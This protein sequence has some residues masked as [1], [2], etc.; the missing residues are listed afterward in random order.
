MEP[1]MKT[2]GVAKSIRHHEDIAAATIT[3]DEGIYEEFKN[4]K[5]RRRYRYI[6]MKIVEAKVVIESTAPPTASFESFIAALP[7]ADS[8]YAV[9][10]HEFTTTDGRKS[11]RLYF[12]TWIPQSSAPG[13]KMAYTHAKNAIR[14]PLEGIYDL[15]AVTK[16]EIIDVL[17]PST[18][19]D[20]E[21]G[22]DFEDD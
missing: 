6:V 22:S 9:Y 7:D 14:A 17:G 20:S 5:L 21:S 15:N 11:S 10:D 13:F 12:V 1:H 4:L 18:S 19:K 16:Q 8:R 2:G 3:H